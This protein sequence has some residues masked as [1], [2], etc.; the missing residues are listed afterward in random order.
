M[1]TRV[2]SIGGGGAELWDCPQAPINGTMSS[3]ESSS[4]IERENLLRCRSIL[5]IE[6]PVLPLLQDVFS[7]SDLRTCAVVKALCY[8]INLHKRLGNNGFVNDV[9]HHNYSF[10]VFI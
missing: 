3:T 5:F 1:P 4:A 9:E 10:M 8:L 6:F 7:S 2:S